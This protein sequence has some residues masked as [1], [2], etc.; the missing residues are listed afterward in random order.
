MRREADARRR[1]GGRSE[2][3]EPIGGLV[4]RILERLGVA[5]R[6]ARERTASRWE[7]VVGPEIARHARRARVDGTTLFVEVDSA[8]WMTELDM[9]RRRLLESLNEGRERGRIEKIVFLQAD[10]PGEGSGGRTRERDRD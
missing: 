4:E 2:R 8:A 7:E 6:V 3:P 10:G 9:M 1:R 5:D